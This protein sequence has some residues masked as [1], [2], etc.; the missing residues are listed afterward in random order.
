M[1]D[2]I[3]AGT[4]SIPAVKADWAA[5]LLEMTG[6]SYPENAFELY[7]PVLEWIEA[8]LAADRRPLNLRL[9]L[10]Y[11]NTS[12]IRALIDMLDLLETAHQDGRQVAVVWLYEPDNER[13]ASLA[14]EFRE[15]YTFPF[16]VVAQDR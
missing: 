11:L 7:Q 1:R 15:D 4:D 8:Y 16:E 5:G 14:E 10:L 9:T 13:V 2:L 6:D 12:S 3:V